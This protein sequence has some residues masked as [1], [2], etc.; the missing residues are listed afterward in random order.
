[1]VRLLERL[2]VHLT[3]LGLCLPVVYSCLSWYGACRSPPCPC[4]DRIVG[5]EVVGGPAPEID[6]LLPTMSPVFALVVKS[7]EAIDDQHHLI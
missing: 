5:D 2:L 6:L 1:M 7:H 3:P 4:A